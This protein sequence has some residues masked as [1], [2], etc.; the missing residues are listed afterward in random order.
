M[1]APG[2]F[3]AFVLSAPL[4]LLTADP[5]RA[6]GACSIRPSTQAEKNFAVAVKTALKNALPPAPAG[7]GVVEEGTVAAEE[8]VCVGQEKYPMHISFSRQYRQVEGMEQRERGLQLAL[9]NTMPTSE[10]MAKREALMSRRMAKVQEV[11]DLLQKAG[12]RQDLKEMDRLSKES[13]KIDKRFDAPI[14]AMDE[15]L[16]QAQR[17]ATEKYLLRDAAAEIYLHVN[18]EVSEIMQG[19]QLQVPGAVGAF[20]VSEG[21]RSGESDWR[22]GTTLIFLGN[23]RLSAP[24]PDGPEIKAAMNK[25]LP[26]TKAQTL[27]IQ[28]VA[29]KDR[30]NQLT[31][32][33]NL[34]A[35]QALIR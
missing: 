11:V 21:E 9:M 15:D 20:R 31:Q 3:C 30:A 25:S 17:R 6:D 27:R 5:V 4:M 22:E 35:L 12:E 23:W 26:H 24:K 7:W 13:E 32:K 33:M 28:I 34:N 29:D 8:Q 2:T 14:K 10:Q 1:K 16:A 19:R 18:W